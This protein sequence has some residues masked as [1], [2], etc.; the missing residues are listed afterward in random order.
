MLGKGGLAGLENIEKLV[1]WLAATQ[2]SMITQY[3]VLHYSRAPRSSTMPVAIV[4]HGGHK[5]MQ[6]H[7]R[8]HRPYSDHGSTLLRPGHL[9]PRSHDWARTQERCS[10]R[11]KTHDAANSE[12]KTPNVL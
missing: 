11:R 9:S 2:A 10:A 3:F 12:K 6:H 8:E 1:R 7:V 5:R 4:E